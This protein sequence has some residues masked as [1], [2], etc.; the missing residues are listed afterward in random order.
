VPKLLLR[1]AAETDLDEL[2]RHIAERSGSPQ[3]AI[4]YIRRIRGWCDQLETFPYAGRARDDLRPGIR[5][6]GFERRVV[7]VYTVLPSGDVEIGRVFYG[8]QNYE[9]ILSE[10]E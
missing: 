10:E 9:A 8:G 3:T 6:L 4:D 1:P 7:I 2:Y 5:I